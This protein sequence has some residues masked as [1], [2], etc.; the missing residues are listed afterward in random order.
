MPLEHEGIYPKYLVFKHP[1]FIPTM[2]DAWA[3]EEISQGVGHKRQEKL[4]QV[5]DFVFVLK[6]STD[7]DAVIALAAYAMAVRDDNPQLS[8]DLRGIVEEY[9]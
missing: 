5:K 3:Y 9:R 8:A 4:T 1:F 7:K 2:V 6:P